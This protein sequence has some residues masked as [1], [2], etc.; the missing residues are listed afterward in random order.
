[1]AKPQDTADT[2]Q[3]AGSDWVGRAGDVLLHERPCHRRVRVD[4]GVAR[5]LSLRGDERSARRGVRCERA[6][7]LLLR[8]PRVRIS[9]ELLVLGKRVSAVYLANLALV[10]LL[11][12]ASACRSALAAGR[13]R[14]AS[15]PHLPAGYTRLVKA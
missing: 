13:R 2:I 7:A 3:R 8:P 1:M 6:A 5:G 9:C 4:L 12:A 14:R 15:C 10:K 11:E